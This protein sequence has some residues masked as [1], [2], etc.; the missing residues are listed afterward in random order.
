MKL[1]GGKCQGGLSA[2]KLYGMVGIPGEEPADVDQTVAMMRDIKSCS[3]VTLDTGMQHV[4]SQSARRFS[5]LGESASREAV[6]GVAE[7]TAIARH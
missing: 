3:R 5:G 7:T 1:G 6:A 2:L 4:C